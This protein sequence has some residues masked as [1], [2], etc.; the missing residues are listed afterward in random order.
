MMMIA[1]KMIH[2]NI[3][4]IRYDLLCP[5]T[6]CNSTDIYESRGEVLGSIIIQYSNTMLKLRHVP[7]HS[8]YSTYVC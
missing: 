4:P 7:K 6:S 1:A 5:F 2:K 3:K 8:N